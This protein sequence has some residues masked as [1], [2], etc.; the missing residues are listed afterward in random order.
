[1]MLMRACR[2]DEDQEKTDTVSSPSDGPDSINIPIHQRHACHRVRNVSV[3]GG[4]EAPR[5]EDVDH[6][7]RPRRAREVMWP[8][9]S[10]S[11]LISSK[12]T[13]LTPK[14][15]HPMLINRYVVSA[16]KMPTGTSDTEADKPLHAA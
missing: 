12:R 7:T 16:R 13:F 8:H 3:L 6:V 1:M 14:P 9:V 5:Q 15:I 11:L 4:R 10:C 2:H